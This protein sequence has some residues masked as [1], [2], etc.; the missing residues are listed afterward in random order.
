MVQAEYRDPDG[1]ALHCCNT[2]IA[3]LRLTLF[4][5]ATPLGRWRE[6]ARLHAPRGGHFEVA[7]RERDP[8]IGKA[9]RRI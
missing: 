7:G 2:E 6:A 8:A 3:D 4:R 9:H 5:R 1:A